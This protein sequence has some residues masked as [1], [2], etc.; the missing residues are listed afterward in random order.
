VHVEVSSLGHACEK[1]VE[2]E[3]VRFGN[4]EG[5]EGALVLR[6]RERG[7]SNEKEDG[8]AEETAHGLPFSGESGDKD[9]AGLAEARWIAILGKRRSRRFYAG[10]DNPRTVA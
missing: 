2:L 9:N 7:Q 4:V 3:R 1:G 8:E 10:G 5:A 6:L